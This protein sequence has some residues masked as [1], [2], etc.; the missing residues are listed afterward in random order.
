MR[1]GA[2][3]VVLTGSHAR[4][5]AHVTSDIDILAFTQRA[6]RRRPDSWSYSLGRRNG[7]LVS[8]GWRTPA[9]VRRRFAQPHRVCTIIPGWR[10]AIILHDPQGIAA[11]LKR[12]AEAWT[13]DDV[14]A[15]CDAWVAEEITGY[16]EE[17]Q[18]LAAAI[19]RADWRNAAIQRSILAV[20]LAPIL[21]VHLRLLYGTENRL[22]TLVDERIGEPW[23]ST[24]ARAL[25]EYGESM[26]VSCHAA[27]K[28][29]A[30]AVETVRPLLNRRQ[31]AVVDGAIRP[32]G[33]RGSRDS[34]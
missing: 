3:A 16:A 5:D 4:G 11:R 10:Q 23:T 15:A 30:L 12:R 31:R 25:S 8:I 32:A 29:Y 34:R 7:H 2:I 14:A 22:W 24:Q 13:W 18:K 9:E 33:G 17:A 21:A 19:A 26:T 20:H 1:D 27:F 6:P 28:L